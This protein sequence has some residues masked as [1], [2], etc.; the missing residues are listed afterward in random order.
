M[1]VEHAV[2]HTE[3][4][5]QLAKGIIYKSVIYAA[6]LVAKHVIGVMGIILKLVIYVSAEPTCALTATA[7]VGLTLQQ[8]QSNKFAFRNIEFNYT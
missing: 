7:L 3:N 1:C 5:A 6:V 4:Y 8:S 2:D